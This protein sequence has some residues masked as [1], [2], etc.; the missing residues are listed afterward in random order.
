MKYSL[1]VYYNYVNS[2][3]YKA[4]ERKLMPMNSDWKNIIEEGS[5]VLMRNNRIFEV[6]RSIIHNELEIHSLSG[7]DLQLS[8]SEY[9]DDLRYIGNYHLLH[10]LDIFRIYRSKKKSMDDNYTFER[11]EEDDNF[12]LVWFR[13]NPD[14][15]VENESLPTNEPTAKIM[16][17]SEIEKELGYKIII[18]DEK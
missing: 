15:Y 12:Q 4:I 9:S 17:K 1:N 6:V 3:Y 18:V 16:T 10:D 2:C 8:L 11:L 5:I 14:L 13:F 7:N